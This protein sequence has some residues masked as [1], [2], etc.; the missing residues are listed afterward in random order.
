MSL[1]C[2]LLQAQCLSW[3]YNV[4]KET[5]WQQH[6]QDYDYL[7]KAVEGWRGVG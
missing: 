3:H 6:Q 2:R 4:P 5:G 7:T 1:L